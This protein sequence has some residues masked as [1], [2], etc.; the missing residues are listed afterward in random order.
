MKTTLVT[1]LTN[2]LGLSILDIVINM[3]L[4]NGN[5]KKY[6][7]FMLN[8]VMIAVILRVFVSGNNLALLDSYTDNIDQM[9]N[10]EM[11]V[12]NAQSIDRT[13][14]DQIEKMFKRELEYQILSQLE[15][16]GKYE[17]LKVSIELDERDDNT[18][19]IESIYVGLR[20]QSIGDSTIDVKLDD[21]DYSSRELLEYLSNTYNVNRENI[22]IDI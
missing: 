3:V 5:F 2:I 22:T 13:Q 11:P 16:M 10:R 19:A 12:I 15:G 7:K 20:E 17:G 6:A 21:D 9:G 1:L 14:R 18:Y 4:P 8:I